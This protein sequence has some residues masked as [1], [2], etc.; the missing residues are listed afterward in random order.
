MLRIL[1]FSSWDLPSMASCIALMSNCSHF[2]QSFII[3]NGLIISFGFK[4]KMRK[5]CN[6]QRDNIRILT[7]LS[8]MSLAS[9]LLGCLKSKK[10]SN[11]VPV[12][13]FKLLSSYY[14]IRSF[15]YSIYIKR[16]LILTMVNPLSIISDF[17]SGDHF[18]EFLSTIIYF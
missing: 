12:Y 13:C 5:M 17:K 1:L 2:T 11:L 3:L 9:V 14:P 16:H 4:C 10:F 6:L 15:S 18:L 7:R 8:R